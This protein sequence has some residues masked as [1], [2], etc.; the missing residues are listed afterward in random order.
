VVAVCDLSA[1]RRD[2]A[3]K[4][5]DASNGNTDCVA[6]NDFRE[7]LVRKDIDAACIWGGGEYPSHPRSGAPTVR[8]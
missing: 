5:V 3:K 4:R 7:L 2:T 6:Y 8:P 1:I